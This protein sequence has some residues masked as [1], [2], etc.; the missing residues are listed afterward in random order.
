MRAINND[1]DDPV[2]LAIRNFF[3]NHYSYCH[4]NCALNQI[5]PS[6][7]ISVG[8]PLV[9]LEINNASPHLLPTFLGD[10][11]SCHMCVQRSWFLQGKVPDKLC[12]ALICLKARPSRNG[13]TLSPDKS[14]Q[15]F[16][17]IGHQS[18]RLLV[19]RLKPFPQIGF[20]KS[21]QLHQVEGDVQN[22]FIKE[23]GMG[24]KR[25]LPPTQEVFAR[26]PNVNLYI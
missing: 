18:L 3:V 13:Q 26:R 15:Y 2:V 10:R 14:M 12:H 5:P 6:S 17:Q 8:F 23:R 24:E 22:S 16:V 9:D 25:V 1:V 7:S 21:K 20:L 4:E 19:N 11:S